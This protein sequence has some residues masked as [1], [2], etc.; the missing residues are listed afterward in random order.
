[1]T[2][3]FNGQPIGTSLQDPRSSSS[4]TPL[5]VAL[6]DQDRKPDDEPMGLDDYVRPPNQ[7]TITD[8]W[9]VI[10]QKAK[11]NSSAYSSAPSRVER[12]LCNLPPI[13]TLDHTEWKGRAETKEPSANAARNEDDDEEPDSSVS[14]VV[15]TRDVRF[16]SDLLKNDLV[17]AYIPGSTEPQEM[18]AGYVPSVMAKMIKCLDQYVAETM[19]CSFGMD[20]ATRSDDNRK[21]KTKHVKLP[22]CY[23]YDYKEEQTITCDFQA[24]GQISFD[25]SGMI[26]NPLRPVVIVKYYSALS[27]KKTD[28]AN[29]AAANPDP[30]PPE[31]WKFDNAS[32]V[33]S[34]MPR[35]PAYTAQVTDKEY[36]ST[37]A[38][39]AGM[40]ANA[41]TA[42][43]QEERV[44]SKSRKDKDDHQFQESME[45]W[46]NLHKDLLQNA[47]R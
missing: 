46:K 10:G 26:K 38:I 14:R 32:Q 27:Q 2:L 45:Y 35:Q 11:S 8:M 16:A 24:G 25:Y 41:I 21:K 37:L 13:Y 9:R 17:K 1:M 33:D 34:S 22:N 47:P 39:I 43:E 23:V 20:P 31:L 42:A 6:L 4:A 15:T 18:G 29:A 3:R 7:P 19:G 44:R 5:S 40:I 28:T 30:Q 36:A 12:D